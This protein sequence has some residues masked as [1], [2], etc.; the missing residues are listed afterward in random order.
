ML[1]LS[2]DAHVVP[3]SNTLPIF[4]IYNIDTYINKVKYLVPVDHPMV[5]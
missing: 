5:I 2:V 1:T 4:N 3:R